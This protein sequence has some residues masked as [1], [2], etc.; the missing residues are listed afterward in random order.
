MSSMVT[1]QPKQPHPQRSELCN[2]KIDPPCDPAKTIAPFFNRIFLCSQ[3][4]ESSVP[5]LS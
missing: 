2:S 5:L 3:V 4:S 1:T